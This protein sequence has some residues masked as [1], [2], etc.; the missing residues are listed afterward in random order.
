[1]GFII[2]YLNFFSQHPMVSPNY[3]LLWAQPLNILFVILLPIKKLQKVLSYYQVLN[4][5]SIIIAISGYLFLPQKFHIAFLPLMIIL[6]VRAIH[7]IRMQQV[8]IK[9][10]PQ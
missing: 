2:F 5:I 8:F 10:K 6:L 7:Y 9:Q 3:N 1:M 4:A